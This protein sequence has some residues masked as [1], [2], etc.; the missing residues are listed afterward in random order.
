MRRK[1]TFQ[2]SVGLRKK[3]EDVE[4]QLVCKVFSCHKKL[5]NF[6]EFIAHLKSHLADGSGTVVSCPYEGCSNSFKL[7]SSF[8]SH[9]SRKHRDMSSADVAASATASVEVN[10]GD[11]NDDA[12]EDIE[13]MDSNEQNEFLTSIALF[14]LKLQAKFLLPA[15]TVQDILEEFQNVHD[16]G[17]KHMCAW[18]KGQLRSSNISSVDID[19]LLFD[20]QSNDY[21]KQCNAGVL[22]SQQ[23]RKSFYKTHFS[24]VEPTE[25][26]LGGDETGRHRYCYYVPVKASLQALFWQKSVVDQYH[27]TH[28]R[29]PHC[30]LLEDISDGAVFQRSTFFTSEPTA[31]KLLLYTDSFEVANPLGSGRKK[32]KIHAVYYTLGDLQ[33][34]NR[35]SIDQI[36]LAL[37]CREIDF[38]KFGIQKVYRELVKDLTDLE[39]SGIQVA[40]NTVKGAVL[41]VC[42]DNLG[43]PE[44]GGFNTSFGTAEYFCRYCTVSRSSLA[45]KPYVTGLPRTPENYDSAVSSQTLGV[46]TSSVL[47][48]L[49]HFHVCQPGLAPCLAHDVFE[50]V[51]SI[52]LA[53]YIK[54]FVQKKW[55]TYEQLNRAIGQFKYIGADAKDKPSVLPRSNDKL[56]GQAVQ[57]WV[58]LRLFPIII[59]NWIVNYTDDVWQLVL[60]LREIVQ[61]IVALR[62]SVDQIGYL[63]C[64]ISEYLYDRKH[65]F[66]EQ[67]FIPKHHYLAHYADLIL[68]FGPLIRVW[69]MRF[70]SKHK[71]FKQCVRKCQNFK[72]ACKTVS[73]RHQLLQAYLSTGSLFGEQVEYDVALAFHDDD[74][75]TEI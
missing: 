5:N 58:F 73:E 8:T 15:S 60:K 18:L 1:H 19:Q 49:N 26:Y 54:Y 4:M 7:K 52:D 31:I 30:D 9:L 61:M 74:Y 21:L 37:L 41:A 25:V 67:R 38:K 57:N 51:L 43:S 34:H 55:F 36:Q 17:Q 35:S 59:G 27:S 71:Y 48:E 10:V 23:S 62:I 40:G 28:M 29:M 3:S 64:L 65:L 50:G 42:G 75:S 44:I 56:C 12:S 6:R 45:D 39:V 72:N 53:L 47:N 20:L 24:Y 69:T 14:Y 22:R 68:Q 2:Q 13:L 16:I 63:K 32:H 70:E 33:P 11:E 46:V 66:P